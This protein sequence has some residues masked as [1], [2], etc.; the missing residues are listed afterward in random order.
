[1]QTTR[2]ALQLTG[3]QQVTSDEAAYILQ[4]RQMDGDV[5]R[6]MDGSVGGDVDLTVWTGTRERIPSPQSVRQGRCQ[7]AQQNRT[8][9]AAPECRIGQGR[10]RCAEGGEGRERTHSHNCTCKQKCCLKQRVRGRGGLPGRGGLG[11]QMHAA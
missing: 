6:D 2:K 5:G 3:K 9:N 10:G 11:A 4:L 7:R 8:T 1:M